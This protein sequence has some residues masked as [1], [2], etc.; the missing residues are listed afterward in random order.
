MTN[1]FTSAVGKKL[2][3][4]HCFYLPVGNVVFLPGCQVL[5]LVI[6]RPGLPTASL[7]LSGSSRSTSSKPTHEMSEAAYQFE[8]LRVITEQ[9]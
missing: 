4:S 8:Y 5:L 2:S 6:H 3:S 1:A 7:E 9:N